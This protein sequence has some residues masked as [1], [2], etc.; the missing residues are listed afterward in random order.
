MT[1]NSLA[2]DLVHFGRH[3]TR[4]IMKWVLGYQL[5]TPSLGSSSLDL[6][7]VALAKAQIREKS[8]WSD[9]ERTREYER[10]FAQWNGSKYA[11]AFM[12]GRTALSACIYALN[13]K[14][15]DEVILP[16]Y[17]CVVVPNA[18]H[19][20][21]IKTV[22]SDIELDTFGLDASLIEEKITSKTKAILLHHL[23]GLVCRDYE[24]ILEIAQKHGL[25]VIE[26]CAQSTGAEFKNRKTGNLGD[27]AIYSSEQS[28]V[29]TTIQGG[30]ATTNDNLLA[31]RLKEYY[32]QADYP[33][34]EFIHKQLYC[35]IINYYSYK[36]PQ[37]WWK[38][39]LIRLRHKDKI[40][41]STTKEEEQG[42]RPANY[43]CKMPSPISAIGLNQLNK[44]DSYNRKRR[45]TA[46]RW[47]KWCE[48]N[49][50]KKPLVIPESIPVY[51][52]YPVMVEAERKTNT[53]WAY[54]QLGINLGVWFVS[55]IHPVSGEIK[56]CP[57]ASEAVKR[58]VNFPTLI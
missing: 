14:P 56:D 25:R 1:L 3:Q 10:A 44:I 43:G 31:Q 50:Y 47:D 33:D 2:V 28:K 19:F 39:E 34:T 38:G 9:V 57:K 18:F 15:D 5:L 36:D 4:N 40:L 7:D 22:Y 41:I 27:V 24:S 21:G 51:L 30:M 23:Y 8:G 58:C 52:R 16:G 12:G 13:L 46:K 49:A 42:I 37:R 54:K 17:T 26:D 45:E 35:V 6:D 11:F 48:I 55:H 29:M 32:Q 53:S 20:E